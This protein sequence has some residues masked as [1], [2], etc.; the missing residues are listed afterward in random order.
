[1][2]WPKF[3]ESL[4]QKGA[5]GGAEAAQRMLNTLQQYISKFNG[6]GDWQILVRVFL[7]IDFLTRK[8]QSEGVVG[9]ELTLRQFAL[10][11]TK[12]QPLFEIVDAGRGKDRVDYKVKGRFSV[13]ASIPASLT[14][15]GQD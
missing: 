6:A 4:L 13:F 3:N 12:S 15:S 14:C 7:N 2:E 5:D 1:M 8:C 11:F 9:D 10:G